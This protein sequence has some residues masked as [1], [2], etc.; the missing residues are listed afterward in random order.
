VPLDDIKKC[1][2]ERLSQK[3]FIRPVELNI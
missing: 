1:F 3:S 2:A